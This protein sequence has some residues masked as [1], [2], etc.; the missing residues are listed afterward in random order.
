MLDGMWAINKVLWSAATAIA[1]YEIVK[2]FSNVNRVIYAV[3]IEDFHNNNSGFYRPA[4]V[5]HIEAL[6]EQLIN[7]VYAINRLSP[8]EKELMLKIDQEKIGGL[9]TEL[10]KAKTSS[11]MDVL[12]SG[13]K[14]DQVLIEEVDAA[15]KLKIKEILK[16]AAAQITPFQEN[17]VGNDIIKRVFPRGQGE[18]RTLRKVVFDEALKTFNNKA[19]ETF[20]KVITSLQNEDSCRKLVKD[21]IQDF[22]NN[23]DVEREDSLRLAEQTTG[24]IEPKYMQ[25]F[26]SDSLKNK[27]PSNS[28]GD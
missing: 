5:T 16:D 3:E 14:F 8:E 2:A 17:V 18:N 19:S 25:K 28:L 11:A 1:A 12:L 21:L 22:C 4:A 7:L 20:E 27:S 15:Q 24:G 10:V 9:F 13:D 23:I 26:Y 6:A